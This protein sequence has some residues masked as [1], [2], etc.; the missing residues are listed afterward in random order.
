MNRGNCLKSFYTPSKLKSVLPLYISTALNKLGI[1]G[2]N[3][4]GGRG[5]DTWPTA[6]LKLTESYREV[7]E[8]FSSNSIGATSAK[9]CIQ[10]EYSLHTSKK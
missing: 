6:D 5:G 10:S 4:S 2:N 3:I 9:I 1:L 7:K 8:K